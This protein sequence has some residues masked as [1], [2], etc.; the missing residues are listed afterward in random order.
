MD[1]FRSLERG[2]APDFLEETFFGK[3]SVTPLRVLSKFAILAPSA[4]E[5]GSRKER[6]DLV[7]LGG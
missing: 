1:C 7:F 6:D 4:D 2:D 5:P 3:F